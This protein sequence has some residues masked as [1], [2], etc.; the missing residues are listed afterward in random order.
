MKRILPIFLCF[1]L[2][3]LTSCSTPDPMTTPK[4]TVTFLSVGK[5]DC[6]LLESGTHAAMIDTGKNKNGDDILSLLSEKGITTLDFLLL[7]H[8]DKDHIGGADTVLSG[9]SV[10]AV[11]AP[12]YAKDGKQYD[13][14]LSALEAS[15]L[16]PTIPKAPLSLPFGD[17]SLEILPPEQDSYDQSNDYSILCTLTCGEVSF[18]FTG[19]AEDVRLSEYLSTDPS[20]CTILKVPHHGNPCDTTKLFLTTVT[21]KAAV[22][23]DSDKDPADPDLLSLLQALKITTY[24]TKSGPVTVQTDGHTYTITQ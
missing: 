6:I 3:P 22:I 10:K 4:L 5:A 1:L 11:Y 9:I 24:E 8:M 23:T 15:G 2:F 20:P 12:D 16:T 14:Y 21:P 17:C 7:T 18:L 19:D 13:Q